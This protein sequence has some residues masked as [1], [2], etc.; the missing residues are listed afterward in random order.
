MT[1]KGTQ[2]NRSKKVSCKERKRNR[3]W[4]MERE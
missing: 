3:H 4:V 1:K 2:V